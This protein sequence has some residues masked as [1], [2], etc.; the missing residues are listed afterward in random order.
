MKKDE[1]QYTVL[2]YLNF[3]TVWSKFDTFYFQIIC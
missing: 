3:L 1:I 2:E